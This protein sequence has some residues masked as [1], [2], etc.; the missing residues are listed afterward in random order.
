MNLCQSLFTLGDFGS[1]L[2]NKLAVNHAVYNSREEGAGKLEKLD[3][4]VHGGQAF[5]AP[6]PPR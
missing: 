3:L 6:N 1:L 4:E 5:A 2:C